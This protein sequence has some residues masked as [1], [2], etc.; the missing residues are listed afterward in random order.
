[1]ISRLIGFIISLIGVLLPFRLR[2]I[3]CEMIGWL[4]QFCYLVYYGTLNLILR[5]LKNKREV[6]AHEK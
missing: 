3:F 6:K 2:I 5:Q 4:Y 1:M